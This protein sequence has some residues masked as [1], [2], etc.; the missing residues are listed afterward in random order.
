MSMMRRFYLDRHTDASGVSGIGRV[1]EGVVF[2]RGEVVLWWLTSHRTMG[3]Y[4]SIDEMVEIH[5]HQGK[6]VVTWVDL[7]S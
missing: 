6:T 1:A 2:E 4:A 5:G 7:S 3:M